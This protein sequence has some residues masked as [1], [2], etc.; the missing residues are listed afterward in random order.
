MSFRVSAHGLRYNCGE[1]GQRPRASQELGWSTR[2]ARGTTH[3]LREGACPSPQPGSRSSDLTEVE[4][5]A[6][7]NKMAFQRFFGS[8]VLTYMLSG[9][10][11]KALSWSGQKEAVLSDERD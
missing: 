8:T 6:S 4:S 1:K 2:P 11:A 3:R 10:V 7:S 9:A 5:N